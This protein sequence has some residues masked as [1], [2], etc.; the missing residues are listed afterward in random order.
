MA[1]RAYKNAS[2]RQAVR[3]I[4]FND[5]EDCMDVE[6][7]SGMISVQLI[8]D[9]FGHNDEKVAADVIRLRKKEGS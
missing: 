7:M 4:A 8:A 9:I 5:E 3:W 6:T 1:K 2:Y